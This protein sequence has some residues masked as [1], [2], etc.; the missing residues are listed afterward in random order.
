MH[1]PPELNLRR[2][3]KIANLAVLRSWWSYCALFIT[4]FFTLCDWILTSRILS[5]VV[6]V[7][8]WTPSCTWRCWWRSPG[9]RTWGPWRRSC[10]C[11]CCCCCCCRCRRRRAH[12]RGWWSGPRDVW[13]SQWCRITTVVAAAVLLM[14]LL[15]PGSLRLGRAKRST[16]MAWPMNWWRDG[17]P[18]RS[19]GCPFSCCCCRCCCRSHCCRRIEGAEGTVAFVDPRAVVWCCV[20]LTDAHVVHWRGKVFAAGACQSREGASHAHGW[21]RSPTV[22]DAVLGVEV[23]AAGPCQSREGASQGVLLP[24]EA[25]VTTFLHG[26]RRCKERGR[27]GGALTWGE[28]RTCWS[29]WCSNTPSP[30][31]RFRHV[32]DAIYEIGLN[33][34]QYWSTYVVWSTYGTCDELAICAEYETKLERVRRSILQ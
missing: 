20:A 16:L 25:V 11:C 15:M 6:R 26:L 7:C 24:E 10:S 30:P 29:P 19:R 12:C 23:F 32:L 18:C 2:N 28:V 33:V 34:F 21:G 13:P 9:W 17:P 22:E 8:R 1:L 4:C 31:H 14:L 5:T 3:W 27:I